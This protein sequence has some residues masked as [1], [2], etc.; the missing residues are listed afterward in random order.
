M[1]T[2]TTY[3]VKGMS[4]GHCVSAVTE[5]L[6]GLDGVTDVAVDLDAGEATVTSE[7][8]LPQETVAEA[9]DEAGY[10]LA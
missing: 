6:S 5:A 1:A 7:G 9:I 8:P 3:R 10:E 4:C 2:T